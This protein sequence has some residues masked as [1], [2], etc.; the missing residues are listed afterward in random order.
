MRGGKG[1]GEF[2]LAP[3]DLVSVTAAGCGAATPLL[4]L[5]AAPGASTA[6]PGDSSSARASSSAAAAAAT[7]WSVASCAG[8]CAPSTP[9]VA[10]PSAVSAA[11]A[12]AAVPP[13]PA[14]PAT[15]ARVFVAEARVDAI[16]AAAQGLVRYEQ[17]VR[18]HEWPGQ[19]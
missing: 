4:S 17:T 9:A 10:A 15:E 8:A 11:G 12:A 7:G 13:A 1:T 2:Q 14:S 6:G 19:G 3:P 16:A 5:A 18:E